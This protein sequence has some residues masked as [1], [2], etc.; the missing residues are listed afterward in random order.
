M[1]KK[2][3]K[4]FDTTLRDGQQCPGAAMPFNENLEYAELAAD[5]GVDVLE[6]GFP[7]SSAKEF[8]TVHAICK[9]YALR[10][11]SPT[12]TSLC[13]LR[14]EQF[15]DTVKSLQPLIEHKRAR[16]HTYLPVD[17]ELMKSSLGIKSLSEKHK[18][19][20]KV[21][22][23]VKKACDKGLEVQFSPEGYSRMG[24]HFNFTTDLIRAAIDGGARIINCPDTIGGAC[25]RQGRHF[26]VE[27]MRQHAEIISKE[28]PDTP[29]TWS[30]HCHN[31][32]GLALDNTMAAIY[33][34]PATQV[35]GCFNG[36]GE[37]A[38]NAAIEQICMYLKHFSQQDGSSGEYFT[39][40]DFSMIQKISDFVAEHML[41]RQ[42]HWPI[43]G[44]NA[45]RHTSGGHTN[46]VLKNP[47]VY[48]PFDPKETGNQ[49]HLLFGPSSGGNHAKAII[50]KF[51]FTCDH[52]EKSSIAQFIKNYF[53]DRYKGITDEE[54]I[55]AFHLYKNNSS[56][57]GT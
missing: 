46:A 54:L 56:K 4:I 39:K 31:D 55:S 17:P 3:I 50:E 33:E 45:A 32:F 18:Y 20:S 53:Q 10:T 26:F 8:N 13:Q 57:Y 5:F 37:R 35:E 22:K 51:G 41:K 38:G 2:H 34:G 24:E 16:L 21:N 28:F 47:L 14:E 43:S 48:Q 52:Q 27:L 29:I 7:S 6:A 23:F 19:V 40:I 49:I 1:K 25:R 11:W 30:V 15:A 12:V 42:P 44:L 9:K 36:I